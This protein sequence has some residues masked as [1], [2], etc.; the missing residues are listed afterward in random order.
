MTKVIE[1][2]GTTTCP[3]CER[4]KLLCAR[5]GYAFV[6]YDIE[7]SPALKDEFVTRTNGART[8]PQIFVETRRIG[9]FID[10][11]AAVNS[12]EIQQMIGGH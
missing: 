7:T 2:Y 6:Y 10:F 11:Q 9:G 5:L 1:I 3:W 12:G 8:V 4:A